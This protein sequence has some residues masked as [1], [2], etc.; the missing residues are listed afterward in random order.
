M[1]LGSFFQSRTWSAKSINAIER[2]CPLGDAK[3]LIVDISEV[4]SSL[5]ETDLGRPNGSNG[6]Y[7]QSSEI[8]IGFLLQTH[9]KRVPTVRR[10]FWD[11]KF[12]K[13]TTRF[14]AL[15]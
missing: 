5:Q 2:D 8:E 4:D 12:L 11:D 6:R 10:S 3:A 1:D 14:F 9:K 13:N 15:V 7:D